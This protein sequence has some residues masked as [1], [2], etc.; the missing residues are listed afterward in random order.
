MPESQRAVIFVNGVV[1]NHA[2]IETFINPDDFLIAVDG[3]YR[4]M[5]TVGLTPHLLIG[6]LDSVDGEDVKRL[7]AMG[8]E[9]CKYPPEKDETDLEIAFATA[10]QRGFQTLR[11]IGAFGGRMDHWLA[12]LFG[13]THPAYAH[14]DIC[15]EADQQSAFLIRTEG[16]I[17]GRPGDLLSLIPMG[18]TVSGIQTEG[19]KYPLRG[20]TLY[21]HLSRGVSNELVGR[22]ARVRIESGLLLC[23]HLR[24]ILPV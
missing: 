12:N 11:V 24:T 14:M 17:D 8:V 16:V 10:Q 19:L 21:A 2:W 5:K 13:L 22:L 15:Y 1:E 7:A 23:I 9:I 4:H 3:G 6:D 18:G 20:E